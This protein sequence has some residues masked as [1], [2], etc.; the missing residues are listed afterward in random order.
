VKNVVFRLR[1]EIS[2]RLISP[3]EILY[4]VVVA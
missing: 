2:E 1:S 3:N 4:H